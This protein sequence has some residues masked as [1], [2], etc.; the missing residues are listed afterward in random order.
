M[1]SLGGPILTCTFSLTSSTTLVLAFDYAYYG[2]TV[3]FIT[4]CMGST[5]F[6][7]LVFTFLDAVPGLPGVLTGAGFS[8]VGTFSSR[9]VIAP[10][11][12]SSSF[13]TRAL[14]LSDLLGA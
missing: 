11:V 14:F 8:G 2:V 5:S 12:S 6:P 1:I 9:V 13:S 3:S 4:A 7:S 10:P